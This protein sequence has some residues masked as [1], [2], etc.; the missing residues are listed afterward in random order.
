M[1]KKEFLELINN[2]RDK[3]N[4]VVLQDQTTRYGFYHCA[5]VII[6]KG[7]IGNYT[8]V[9]TMRGK[10]TDDRCKEELAKYK[11]WLV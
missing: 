10:T 9:K 8:T 3:F 11:K 1:N 4:C 5:V 2:H 6:W 7:G